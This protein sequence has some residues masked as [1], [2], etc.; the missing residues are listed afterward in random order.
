MAA[1]QSDPVGAVLVGTDEL[2]P[3]PCGKFDGKTAKEL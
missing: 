1:H 3:E 2:T